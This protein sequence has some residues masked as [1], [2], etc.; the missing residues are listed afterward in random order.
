MRRRLKEIIDK[1]RQK[2]AISPEK[3]LT[4]E[5][6]SLPPAFRTSHASKT[7]S[8]RHIVEFNGKYILFW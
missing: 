6:L 2:G 3:A 8:N 1:F 4:L 5:E 7:G